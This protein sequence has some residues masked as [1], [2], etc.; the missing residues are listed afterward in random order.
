MF[1]IVISLFQFD[2]AGLGDKGPVKEDHWWERVFNEASTNVNVQ[3]SK[4][5]VVEVDLHDKD[6]VE[7]TNKSYSMKKLKESKGTLQYGSFLKSATLLANVGKEEEIEGHLS[8]GDIEIKPIKVISDE[9]LFK[10]CGGRTAHKGARHGLNLSGKLKRIAEQERILLEKMKDKVNKHE[11]FAEPYAKKAKVIPVPDLNTSKEETDDDTLPVNPDVDY[12]LKP[13]KERKKRDKK[14]EKNLVA[15]INEI[16][17]NEAMDETEQP[18]EEEKEDRE[19][20][21]IRKKK[22]KS[23]KAEQVLQSICEFE[24]EPESEGTPKRKKKKKKNKRKLESDFDEAK[25]VTPEP[26]VIKYKKV[27][28]DDSYEASEDE[29]DIIDR[30]NALRPEPPAKHKKRS[31]VKRDRKLQ[32]EVA[33][34]ISEQL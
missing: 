2:N 27:K 22:K 20:T 8:T 24:V 28:L 25:E 9:D 10:A 32:N 6:G 11:V 17:L 31:K 1:L 3:K 19:G 30:L 34:K 33:L 16:G 14:N 13:T 21:P 15:K 4:S 12:I 18:L 7:I 26:E 5:G 23:K 29:E